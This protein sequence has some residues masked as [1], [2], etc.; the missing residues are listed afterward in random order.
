MVCSI[1]QEVGQGQ[2]YSVGGFQEGRNRRSGF[3]D[4]RIV[5]PGA[6]VNQERKLGTGISDNLPQMEAAPGHHSTHRCGIGSSPHKGRRFCHGMGQHNS[7]LSD[8]HSARA[9]HRKED[10]PGDWYVR[11]SK[12]T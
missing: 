3:L 8:V 6:D 11:M 9:R 4:K 7:R 2:Q 12:C 5:P 1:P 10:G